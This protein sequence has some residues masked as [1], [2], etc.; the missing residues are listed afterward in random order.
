MK[1]GHTGTMTDTNGAHRTAKSTRTAEPFLQQ[2][3]RALVIRLALGVTTMSAAAYADDTWGE[4]RGCLQVT[5]TRKKPLAERARV[6]MAKDADTPFR[7]RF[8]FRTSGPHS[9]AALL[10]VGVHARGAD[11]MSNGAGVIIHRHSSER[12]LCGYAFVGDSLGKLH[13]TKGE[14]AGLAYDTVYDVDCIYTPTNR[15]LHAGFNRTLDGALAGTSSLR[16][17]DGVTWR[18]DALALWNYADG[19]PK[20]ANSSRLTVLIDRLRLDDLEPLRFDGDLSELPLDSGSEAFAWHRVPEPPLFSALT[21]PGT[22][23]PGQAATCQVAVR[24]QTMGPVRFSLQTFTGDVLLQLDA[25][26]VDN[27]ATVTLTGAALDR[28]VRGE[29]AVTATLPGRPERIARSILLQGR[30][31]RNPA[32]VPTDV[33]PGDELVFDDMGAFGPRTAISETSQKG[34]WWR[35]PYRCESSEDTRHMLCV[36]EHDPADPRGCLAPALRLPLTVE[37]WY[38]VWVTTVR[39]EEGGGIDVRLSDDPYFLHLDPQQIAPAKK[40]RSGPR[41]VDLR[42]R[43]A[44]LTGQG[45]VF[46][47]PFGTYDS[48]TQLC[49]AAV[50]G[51]RLVRLS[52]EQVARHEAESATPA[53]RVIGFD[54]DGYSYFWR[55]GTQDP[56]CIARLLEPLRTPSAAFLHFSLGGLGG[57]TIPTPYTELFQLSGHVRDGDFRAN[58]FFRWCR[59][60]DVNIV[61]VLAERA[62]E[63]GLELFV[64]TMM[65][66]SYSRDRFIREHPEWRVQRG[67]GTWDYAQPEVQ[68][69]Q[70]RKIAW[71]CANHDIDGFTIDFTRY[72]H[73]FNEDEPDKA[74][75]MNRFV[76]ALRRRI[77]EVNATKARRVKLCASFGDESLF[78]RHWGTATLSDQGL[79]PATW[80]RESVF[81]ILMP[82]GKTCL[83]FVRMAQSTRTEVWPRKVSGYALPDDEPSGR[84]GPTGIERCVKQVF[85]AGAPGVFF[86]N[87]ET[88]TTL[89]RLGVRKELDLRAATETSYA[90]REGKALQFPDWLPGYST[91]K[92]LRASFVPTTVT[93]ELDHVDSTVLLPLRNSFDRAVTAHVTWTT[94]ESADGLSATPV[95]SECELAPGGKATLTARIVGTFPPADADTALAANILYT[96]GRIAVFRARVP[97]R[98]VPEL[99]CA[100]TPSMDQEAALGKDDKLRVGWTQDALRV[101]VALPGNP[102]Q[103]TPLKHDDFRGLNKRLCVTLLVASGRSEKTYHAFL[104]DGN[105]SRADA[106]W[107]YSAFHNKHLRG[108]DW[109]GEWAVV[110]DGE[111]DHSQV[112]FTVPFATL[113]GKPAPAA[114]WRLAVSVRRAGPPVDWPAEHRGAVARFG[115]LVFR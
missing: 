54:N 109:G 81:D 59:D 17:P 18:S 58:A 11:F 1:H 37:G 113:E 89:G 102:N 2:V 74:Q 78:M 34:V 22:V 32:V 30:I 95:Q 27:A 62:H 71:I 15:T 98:L 79:D 93:A 110:R 12:G 45:L 6:V 77:D 36:K 21:G 72:G 47:Q 50:A 16:L 52:P 82:E 87:H 29:H 106:R 43:N 24:P 105:G 42:F 88:W 35:R 19:L 40:S 57:L 104:T 75:H 99:V 60:E 85:D 65:E 115:R 94:A 41:L 51:I 46:Q 91:C 114:C 3:T 97:V 92:K 39:G 64:A 26:V 14:Q 61:K 5:A 28:L 31:F 20:V 83:D 38:E 84:L 103:T 96:A 48:A 9:Y 44:D 70:I 68:A 100:P 56:A 25:P 33:R 49:N 10:F 13:L 66:R 23:P 76:R 73:F 55:W 4:N 107:A 7:L 8:R 108:A 86:F 90:L 101:T 67:R 53:T 112:T 69:F 111:A 63:L 80:I